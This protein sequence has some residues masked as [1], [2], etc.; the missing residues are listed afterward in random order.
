MLVSAPPFSKIECASELGDVYNDIHD[1]I[2]T[3]IYPKMW[4]ESP[5]SC[6]I[7]NLAL[8]E[9]D[10]CRGAELTFKLV[11]LYRMFQ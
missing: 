7:S 11:W 6:N 1:L 8:W 9:T 2:K 4:L 10:A 5:N 3:F